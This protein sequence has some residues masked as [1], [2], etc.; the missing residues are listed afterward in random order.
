M[1]CDTVHSPSELHLVSNKK[2]PCRKKTC[3]QRK[4]TQANF[5][6]LLANFSRIQSESA[7]NTVLTPHFLPGYRHAVF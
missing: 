5:G 4:A 1:T 2:I 6:E 3:D 7:V